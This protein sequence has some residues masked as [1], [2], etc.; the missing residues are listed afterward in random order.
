LICSIWEGDDA[1]CFV[2]L[3][4]WGDRRF[5]SLERTFSLERSPGFFSSVESLSA[6]LKKRPLFSR[7]IS[8]SCAIELPSLEGA[9]SAPLIGEFLPPRGHRSAR[10]ANQENFLK[11]KFPKSFRTRFPVFIGQVGQ[12]GPNRHRSD[13]TGTDRTQPICA[14]SAPLIGE[15]LPSHG[16]RSDR[17]NFL[18]LSE[19]DS[20]FLSVR[21]VRSARIGTDRIEPAQIGTDRTQPICAKSA[22]LIGKCPPSHGHRS[23]RSANQK[24][25]FKTKF[26]KSFRTRFSVF[27]RQF[28]Q[29]GPNRHR[30]HRTGTRSAQIARKRSV[31]NPPL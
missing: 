10:S 16:H 19:Q 17:K 11:T 25:F 29:I 30:S 22:S 31:R 9:K 20:P 18:D 7:K 13:R 4:R 8:K 21:S 14:K 2:D 24:N 6:R 1:T 26:P 28:G 15:F 27:I 23:H 12:I 3:E 5:L